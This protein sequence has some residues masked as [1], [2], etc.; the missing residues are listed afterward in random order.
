M[1]VFLNC[2]AENNLGD[3]I[4][5][6]M[7]CDRYDEE[8]FLINKNS[9]KLNYKIKNLKVINVNNFV[10]KLFRKIGAFFS[11]RNIIESIILKNKDCLVTIGGSMFMEGKNFKK[12]YK[13]RQFL[14]Y[15]KINKP[16]YI[17]GA[18]IGPIYTREYV[19]LLMQEALKNA[20]DV[21]LRDRNSFELVSSLKN[22]RCASD[23]VFSYDISRYNNLKSDNKIIISVIDMNK[24]S[25]QI[26]NPNL[27][28]YEKVIC[29]L[30]DYF[31]LK[32]FQ[33]ELMSFCKE[34][35][36]EEAIERILKKTKHQEKISKYLYNGN[37][38]EAISELASSKIII[39]TR[40]HAN[41]LGLM[42]NKTI[43]PII[44][45]DKTRNLLR[46]LTFEGRYIDIDEIEKF[47]ID[48][49]YNKYL[50]YKLDVTFQRKDAER[51]FEKLDFIL[52]RKDKE[53]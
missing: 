24:K 34:E 49:L 11:R 17:I 25:E 31:I 33:V 53:K 32:N 28:K 10:Y 42:L 39:G 13:T 14:I 5:I 29:D 40:F 50:N 48:Y 27:E 1:K 47:N 8:F 30:I 51:H 37:I 36:D 12:N 6:K 38:E 45:N 52:N 44:Y 23:I 43:I 19:K 16:Y 22:I 21:C 18:N 4:F 7:I 3:D 26:V 9:F 2:V 15:K 41:I 46:D 35:G 20:T